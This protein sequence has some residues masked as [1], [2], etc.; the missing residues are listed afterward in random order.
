M[1]LA[2]I[3]LGVWLVSGVVTLG[4]GWPAVRFLPWWASLPIMIIVAGVCTI[5]GLLG[6][7]FAVPGD[8]GNRPVVKNLIAAALTL[9]AVTPAAITAMLFKYA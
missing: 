6:S 7:A 1:G 3:S 8:G 4:I 9:N 5:A 2:L